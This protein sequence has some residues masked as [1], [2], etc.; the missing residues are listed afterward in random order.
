LHVDNNAS[1][2]A[3][4]CANFAWQAFSELA[5]KN[6]GMLQLAE[7]AKGTTFVLELPA[8]PAAAAAAAIPKEDPVTRSLGRRAA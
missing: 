7:S 3:A 5:E 2:A 6:G 1:R 8:A 4:C